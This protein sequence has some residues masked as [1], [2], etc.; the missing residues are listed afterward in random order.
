MTALRQ[1]MLQDLRL[2]GYAPGTQK[3]YVAAVAAFAQ[4]H[5]R[6]PDRLGGKELR[7]YLLHL[8]EKGQVGHSRFKIIISG[9]RFFYKVTL[10][11][12]TELGFIPYPRKHKRLPVVLSREEMARLLAAAASLKVLTLLMTAYG[13]GLRISELAGLQVDDIDS[14]RMVV[15][16]R[17][18]KGNKDRYVP[19]SPLLLKQLRTF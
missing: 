17:Q 15:R 19:L 10:G 12:T 3:H 11:R 1:R 4:Y 14:S 9:L 2:R 7:A 18:G 6:S 5:H 8:L 16:V 13:C